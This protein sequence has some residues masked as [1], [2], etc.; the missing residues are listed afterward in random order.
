MVLNYRYSQYALR[1]LLLF[2]G[3]TISVSLL[4]KAAGASAMKNAI[5]AARKPL[6]DG[7][8]DQF[9]RKH[10][11]GGNLNSTGYW[12]TDNV[13]YKIKKSGLSITPAQ[14][15][16]VLLHRL[17]NEGVITLK[18][19]AGSKFIIGYHYQLNSSERLACWS[20]DG[21]HITL[22]HAVGF[23]KLDTTVLK[24]IEL[25]RRI[26]NSK[27]YYYL[28]IA[29]GP[30]HQKTRQTVWVWQEDQYDKYKSLYDNSNSLLQYHF[31]NNP[32]GL[33]EGYIQLG[34]LSGAS[35]F[36]EIRIT[37]YNNPDNYLT[38]KALF[39]GNWFNTM[40]GLHPSPAALMSFTSGSEIRFKVKNTTTA[41]LSFLLSHLQ[42]KPYQ[43]YV[44]LQ[45]R[46]LTT[47]SSW[48]GWTRHQ[49]PW[50]IPPTNA[51]IAL[52]NDLDKTHQYELRCVIDIYNGDSCWLYGI[53][54]IVKDI[55]VDHGGKLWPSD[56]TNQP[57]IMALGN[58]ITAGVRQYLTSS[59]AIDQP[60]NLL[61]YNSYFHIA[62]DSF[63]ALPYNQAFGGTGINR[64]WRGGGTPNAV[65]TLCYFKQGR[66]RKSIQPSLILVNEGT[67]DNIK[68]TLSFNNGYL[69]LIDSLE[70]FYPKAQIVLMIPF[71]Q[72]FKAPIRKIAA[73]KQFKVIETASWQLNYVDGV[74]PDSASHRKAGDSLF[75]WIKNNIQL[76][77]S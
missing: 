16:G 26:Q 11:K 17:F 47:R 5:S 55:L 68:D 69:E 10:F 19:K 31:K 71:C 14:G 13:S 38:R 56:I 54:A 22:G 48:S 53:G 24:S 42:Q 76:K 39:L 20:A 61:S 77:S 46:D 45:F 41:K 1:W 3:L 33:Q 34:S 9:D 67:N 36:R 18:I 72:K 70:A 12:T 50:T 62:C 59:G 35:I 6:P 57:V 28:R 29:L 74:H 2:T 40:Q 21:K 63:N 51:T 4:P 58:S 75:H 52:L 7:H 32:E 49:I 37:D 64:G 60:A 27:S 65:T 8:Y 15:S 43:P 44:D 25:P 23:T 73:L 30:I 66:P